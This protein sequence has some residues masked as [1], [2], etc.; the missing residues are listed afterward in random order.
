MSLFSN[1]GTSEVRGRI[2]KLDKKQELHYTKS[3]I[4]LIDASLDKQRLKN[5]KLKLKILDQQIAIKKK[6][7]SSIINLKGKSVWEKDNRLMEVLQLQSQKS[8]L[9]NSIAI[10]EENIRYKTIRLDGCYLKEFL[11]SNHQFVNIGT[12][13]FVCEEHNRA[14]VQLFVSRAER[15]ILLKQKESAISIN[16]VKNHPFKIIKIANSTDKQYLS[17]YKIE[18]ESKKA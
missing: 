13:L 17:S 15:D 14:K 11:T 12:K 1:R 3:Y 9:L 2:V 10:L 7:Y 8:D 18:L 6:S 5:L 16:G 4:I